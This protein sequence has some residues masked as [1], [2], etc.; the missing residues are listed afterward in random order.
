MDL[1]IVEKQVCSLAE[2]I[3]NILGKPALKPAQQKIKKE[4]IGLIYNKEKI[5][6][7]PAKN[8]YQIAL[9]NNSLVN[10]MYDFMRR[11]TGQEMHHYNH[12]HKEREPCWYVSDYQQVRK[13]VYFFAGIDF[14]RQP[15]SFSEFAQELQ[16]KVLESL[17]KDSS[18]RLNRIAEASKL[19]TRILVA[20]EVFLRN[21]DVVAEALIRASGTCERCRKAA[22]FN[23]KSDGSP[24]LEVHHIKR[25]ADGGEDTLE[26]VQ[27][28]CPNCHRELHHG[29]TH[30]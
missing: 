15:R 30:S 25:L 22:P 29:D 14:D 13:A 21:P 2:E 12:K 7:R 19:P 1:E 17:Q 18:T 3:N 5:Y 24:Y 23:R 10:R 28:L 11:L 27:A 16:S 26:N 6:I 9:S 4:N 20:A 8:G